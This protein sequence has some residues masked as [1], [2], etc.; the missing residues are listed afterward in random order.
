MK[1]KS[2]SAGVVTVIAALVLATGALAR[3]FVGGG[4]GPRPGPG[5][6][7]GFGLGPEPILPRVVIPPPPYYPHQHGDSYYDADSTVV[8][9]QRALKKRG[10]YDGPVDGEAGR[11]TRVAILNF[12]ED[13]G[14]AANSR[15]D[16]SL[17]LALGL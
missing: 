5:P 10:Y 6:G 7:P 1:T 13:H 16:R 9:V 8:A 15:I 11:A 12:R 4:I 17:L 3:P 14:L 2:I